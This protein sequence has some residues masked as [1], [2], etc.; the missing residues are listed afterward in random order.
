MSV[1]LL[2]KYIEAAEV[3]ANECRTRFALNIG[4]EKEEKGRKKSPLVHDHEPSGKQN[5]DRNR[6]I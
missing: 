3:T 1:C 6:R 5:C 4:E 2:K